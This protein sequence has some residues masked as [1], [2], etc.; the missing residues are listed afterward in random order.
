MRS[1]NR[2]YILNP[3]VHSGLYTLCWWVSSTGQ[4]TTSNFEDDDPTKEREAELLLEYIEQFN[5]LF[6]D[7]HYSEAA[8][9]AANS[10]KGILRNPETLARFKGNLKKVMIRGVT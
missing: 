7:K 9:H 6:E 5:D 2:L 1:S 4:D 3:I 8:M 10:P